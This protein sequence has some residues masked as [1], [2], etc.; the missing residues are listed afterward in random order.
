MD[1]GACIFYATQHYPKK[2]AKVAYFGLDEL[3]DGLLDS[4]EKLKKKPWKIKPKEE[5]IVQAVTQRAK[6]LRDKEFK[7][8]YEKPMPMPCSA[9]PKAVVA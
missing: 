8:P 6:D 1:W 5:N 4:G 9:E 2:V 3:V 7:L